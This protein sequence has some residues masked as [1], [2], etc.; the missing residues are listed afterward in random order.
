[1]TEEDS[2]RG[3]NTYTLILS[4]FV[5]SGLSWRKLIDP[6]SLATAYSVISLNLY[7]LS[8]TGLKITNSVPSGSGGFPFFLPALF[9]GFKVSALTE[10]SFFSSVFFSR[11]Y[12]IQYDFSSGN[13]NDF[14][15]GTFIILPEG[16]SLISRP[17]FGIISSFSFFFLAA[18][19]SLY[20]G[21]TWQV[22]YLL[23]GENDDFVPL[24]TVSLVPVATLYI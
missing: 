11:R 4:I 10:V 6:P 15:L 19:V 14:T 7:S 24:A 5:V 17:F 23:S 16:N 20:G 21:R 8:S 12:A 18:R 3:S 22:I 1:M 9:T 13:A 2:L